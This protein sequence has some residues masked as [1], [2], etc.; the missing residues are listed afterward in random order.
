M[1]IVILLIEKENKKWMEKIIKE[2][3]I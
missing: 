2:K 1:G 3:Y